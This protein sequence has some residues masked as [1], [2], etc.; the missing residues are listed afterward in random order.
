MI[1][2]PFY[3]MLG[4]GAGIALGI[5]GMRRLQE[6]QRKLSP[7]A[8]VRG[9]GERAG[10][11]RERVTLAITEARAAAAEKE[12]ELRGLYK[13]RQYGSP[14]GHSTGNSDAV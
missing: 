7:Q 4:L 3:A 12:A 2:R 10:S 13:V 14:N 1:R 5:I 8:L 11:L 9:A 6:A